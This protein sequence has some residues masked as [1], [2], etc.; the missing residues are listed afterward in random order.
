MDLDLITDGYAYCGLMMG[1]FVLYAMATFYFERRNT[2]LQES[3][4]KQMFSFRGN[5]NAGFANLNEG[6]S[7]ISN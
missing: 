6:S 7:E 5:N 1:Q 4:W 2:R 3:N